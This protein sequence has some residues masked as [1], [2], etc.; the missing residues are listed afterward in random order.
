MGARAL[1]WFDH[2]ALAAESHQK[3]RP[4]FVALYR[5]YIIETTTGGVNYAAGRTRARSSADVVNELTGAEG[6]DQLARNV[7]QD[8]ASLG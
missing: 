1:S 6:V 5:V 2:C 8:P 3:Q 7:H 4:W